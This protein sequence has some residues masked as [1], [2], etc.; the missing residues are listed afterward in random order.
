MR[1]NKWFCFS[2]DFWKE[3]L[4]FLPLRML[5]KRINGEKADRSC[6]FMRLFRKELQIAYRVPGLIGNLKKE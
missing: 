4:P 5:I 1:I 3:L 6:Q 2:I